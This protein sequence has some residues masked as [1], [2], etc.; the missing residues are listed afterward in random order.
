[1]KK[2]QV[3]LHPDAEIDFTSAFEWGSRVWGR[4]QARAWIQ[5]LRRTLQ[6]RLAL[7]PLGCPLAPES[8]ELGMPVRQLIIDRY[9]I[10]FIVKRRAVTILHLRGPYV[11]P[12]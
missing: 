6:H 9:R 2:Y 11:P 5:N 3:I 7:I 12:S 1:M 8:D 4:K 10:L